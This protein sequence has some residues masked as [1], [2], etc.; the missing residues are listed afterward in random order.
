M[1]F[2]AIGVV[3]VG[4]WL[5]AATQVPSQARIHLAD[6]VVGAV[7]TQ[8]FGCTTL[9]LEPFDDLC[10]M[11]HVH[12]GIDLAAATG[13]EVH[14]A[15]GGRAYTGVD[16]AGAGNFVVVVED[17]H[18]RLIYCHLDAFRVRSGDAV[19]PGQVIG[20]VGST[21]LATGPHVHFQVDV[22]GRPVDPAAWL[23]S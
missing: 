5:I 4:T 22:D 13:T 2:L 1:R 6:V 18:V 12:T 19:T 7:V 3:V 9:E 10:P 17:A 23:A 14:S 8:P 16:P 21:G 15:T 20:L 11:H